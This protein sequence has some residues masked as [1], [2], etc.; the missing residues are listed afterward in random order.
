LREELE[1]H[2]PIDRQVAT[3]SETDH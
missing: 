2:G 1:E 3:N